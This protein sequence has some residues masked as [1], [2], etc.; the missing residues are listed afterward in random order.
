MDASGISVY[1]R[2]TQGVKLIG[3]EPDERVAAIAK[4]VEKEQD[5]VV[6]PLESE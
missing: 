6:E 3:L 5:T 2:G 4:V 1:G